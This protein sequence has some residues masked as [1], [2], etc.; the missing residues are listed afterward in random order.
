MRGLGA[1]VPM[2]RARVLSFAIVALALAAAPLVLGSGASP[3]EGAT[4]MDVGT[5]TAYHWIG[6]ATEPDAPPATSLAP[7][8]AGALRVAALM[9]RQAEN[10]TAIV[11]EIAATSP[12]LAFEPANATLRKE[13]GNVS[14]SEAF[15]FAALNFSAPTLD[16][17]Y[18]YT[19]T[20]TSF[21]EENGTLR[22]LASA[23]GDGALIVGSA[24]APL[25]AP[26]I[27][28]TWLLAGLAALLVGGG[29]AAYAVR[30]RSIRRRM[31]GAPRSQV[32]REAE[33]E[34]RLEKA[35]AKDPEAAVVIQQEIRRAEEV[36]EKRRELQILE[37]KRADALKTLELLKKRHEGGGLTKL[38]YD[39]MA[40]KKQQDLARIEAEI[41]QMEREDQGAAA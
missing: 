28:R 9:D 40:A 19:V 25:P 14:T 29:A 15:H 41:A 11:W 12:T 7:G 26:A 27:P 33:L 36:R 10:A 38:Q 4:R 37:A 21:A 5:R 8:A 18:A 32:M 24:E 35:K 34:Q 6:N 30:Q 13:Y 20:F 1:P 31:T 2:T 22:Q 16:G 3:P 39:N 23:S 17:T